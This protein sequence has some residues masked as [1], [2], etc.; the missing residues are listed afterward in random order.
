MTKPKMP[1]WRYAILYTALSM[2]NEI[3]LIVVFHLKPPHDN[4]I[5]A[6]II[7]TLPP[8]LAA[9]MAGYR[10]RKELLTLAALSTL[11]TLVVTLTVT[12]VTGVNTGLL[13][14]LI[15]RPVAGFLAIVLANRLC[16]KP[17]AEPQGPA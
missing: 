1:P 7:L 6:P 8:L 4:R 15:N 16:A 3:V 13:E 2:A 17:A 5:I 9:W 10:S 12:H 11:M 14:P